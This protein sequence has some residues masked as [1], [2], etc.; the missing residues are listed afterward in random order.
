MGGVGVEKEELD[1]LEDED[2]HECMTVRKT[3]SQW[4]A[5]V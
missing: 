4:E 2:W 1:E 5:D 3:E